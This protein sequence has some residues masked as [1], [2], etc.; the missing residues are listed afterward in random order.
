MESGS[1]KLSHTGHFSATVPNPKPLPTPPRG[2]RA[3]FGFEMHVTDEGGMTGAL[4][5]YQ[6]MMTL[7]FI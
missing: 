3:L 7:A 6:A 5:G 4:H 1:A 2:P